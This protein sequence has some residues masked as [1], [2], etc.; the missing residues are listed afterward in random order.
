MP[1]EKENMVLI[2]NGAIF[3]KWMKCAK[4]MSGINLA[5][6]D[7]VVAYWRRGEDYDIEEKKVKV[8]MMGEGKKDKSLGILAKNQAGS[9]NLRPS[10]DF[11]GGTSC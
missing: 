6:G 7:H 10:E 8:E 4:T 3:F 1:P 2:S 5:I 11:Q 9:S